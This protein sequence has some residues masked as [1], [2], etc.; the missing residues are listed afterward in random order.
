MRLRKNITCES[1]RKYTEKLRT[2]TANS[3][4]PQ[5]TFMRTSGFL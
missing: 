3:F 1:L 2:K 4:S 5:I